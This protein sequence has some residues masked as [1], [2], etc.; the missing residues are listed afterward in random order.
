M[1]IIPTYPLLNTIMQCVV[2]FCPHGGRI[3]LPLL[4]NNHWQ[5]FYF[6][7]NSPPENKNHA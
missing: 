3:A 6:Q 7:E 2:D 1:N 5:I 4:A